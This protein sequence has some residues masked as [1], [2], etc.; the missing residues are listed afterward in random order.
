MLYLIMLGLAMFNQSIYEK[1]KQ[2]LSGNTAD[3]PLEEDKSFGLSLL[4]SLV[5]VI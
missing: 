1:I 5:R 2:K 3:F 4:L